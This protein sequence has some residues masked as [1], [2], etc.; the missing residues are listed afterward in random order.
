[1]KFAFRALNIFDSVARFCSRFGVVTLNSLLTLA[2]IYTA[3]KVAH[4][5]YELSVK[6]EA[7]EERSEKAA[8]WAVARHI[9]LELGQVVAGLEAK[10]TGFAQAMTRKSPLETVTSGEF[11]ATYV[12][13]DRVAFDVSKD[14]LLALAHVDLDLAKAVDQCAFYVRSTNIAMKNGDN[15]WQLYGQTPD[16]FGAQY[17]VLIQILGELGT[18]FEVAHAD[19]QMALQSTTKFMGE[20]YYS[21]PS[22][23]ILYRATRARQGFALDDG[24]PF[25]ATW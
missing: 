13:A 5:S 4:D 10:R 24:A 18:S 16:S 20:K 17:E 2:S 25:R 19:C 3:Y 8:A 6:A 21:F 22:M 9:E 14:D 12:T 7:R 1:M 11:R 23:D 15:L